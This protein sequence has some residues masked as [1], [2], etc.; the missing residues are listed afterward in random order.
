MPAEVPLALVR[1]RQELGEA[2][3]LILSDLSP[4]PWRACNPEVGGSTPLRPWSQNQWYLQCL[5]GHEAQVKCITLGFSG[6][7]PIWVA[8]ITFRYSMKKTFHGWCVLHDGNVGFHLFVQPPFHAFAP[9]KPHP[10]FVPLRAS[11]PVQRAH[12]AQVIP[13]ASRCLMII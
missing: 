13:R 7:H 1:N 3:S 8:L 11:S 9:A 4:P 12:R 2:N 5:Q 10:A 6:Y